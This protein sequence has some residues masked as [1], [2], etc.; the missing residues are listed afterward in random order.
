[1]SAAVENMAYFGEV[2]WHGLGTPLDGNEST[3]EVMQK[4][5]LDWKVTTEPLYRQIDGNFVEYELGQASVRDIDGKDLGNVGPRW[6]PLQNVQAFK[7]FEPMVEKG[8]M[9]W[10]TAGSLQDGRRVWVL[11]KLNMDN[12]EI[13][14]GDE[15]CKFATLSMGHDGKLAV[16]FGFTPIRIVCANTEALARECAASK[17]IRVRH[18]RNVAANVEKLRDIMNVANQEF[19]AT[20]DEYRYLAS[21]QINKGD[22]EKYIKIVCDVQDTE[23]EDISTRTKNIMT[24]IEELYEGGRGTEI[25]GVT[26]TWWGAYNAV[27]EYLNYEKGRNANNRMNSLWFGQGS[28]QSRDALVAA[29]AL[30][31]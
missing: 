14:A 24:R 20:C 1:M 23:E 16:H 8:L 29:V 6:T 9:D 4:A 5:G 31:A 12:S 2:P 17:L 19:E 11:C 10:H 13:V 3:E 25:A 7:T 27:T 28:V 22:L 26:G 15:I 18:H 30:S 21:R